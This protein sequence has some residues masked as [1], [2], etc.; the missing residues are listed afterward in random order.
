MKRVLALALVALLAVPAAAAV[1]TPHATSS[2]GPAMET[3]VPPDPTGPSTDGI[4]ADPP[5]AT[6]DT[7]TSNETATARNQEQN[8]TRTRLELPG[9]P[10]YNVTQP[11]LDVGTA[12][13]MGD[14]GIA[15][16]YHRALAERRLQETDDAERLETRLVDAAE[17]EVERLRDRERATV[18]AYA[19]NQITEKAFVRR[20]VI[21]S[22]QAN[23]LQTE[24][25]ALESA[26]DRRE[27]TLRIESLLFRLRTYS[28]AAHTQLE[29]GVA[30]NEALSVSV[31]ATQEGYVLGLLD[32]SEGTFYRQA[33]RFDN[34][35]PNG[36]VTVETPSNALDRAR[37]LYP[38]TN[39]S[40][41]FIPSVYG[42]SRAGIYELTVNYPE[43]GATLFLDAAT[44]NVFYEVK[45]QDLDSLPRSIVFNDTKADVRVIVERSYS[46]G[47]TLVRVLDADTGS[48]VD[49]A[50]TV[51]GRRIGDVGADG[52]R[53]FVAPPGTYELSVSRGTTTVNVT[54]PRSASS[55]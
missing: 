46:N 27:T 3:V 54:L 23:D 19:T 53:W 55:S 44:A 17:V 35:N 2:D 10:R 51:D 12:I 21:V 42:A 8:V 22:S 5:G 49:G 38:E 45:Q 52:E 40:D 32:R 16:Q 28:G 20:F 25:Q 43:G 4:V 13:A 48:P 29:R 18:Q 24:L 7:T 36:T 41:V 31:M 37:T 50:L 14:G 26:V 1:G 47:P 33:F 30:G 11:S 39:T 9:N 6:N 34:R 15:S